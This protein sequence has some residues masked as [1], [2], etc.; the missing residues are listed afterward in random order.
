MPPW[1][2]A[3]LVPGM[4]RDL[5]PWLLSLLVV[6]VSAAWLLLDGRQAFPSSGRVLL[7][8]DDPWGPEGSQHLFD[9]YS[10]SHLIHGILFYAALWLVL[11]RLALRWR[12][13]LAVVVECAWELVENSDAVIERYR[14]ATVSKDYLGDSVLNSVTDVLCMAAGFWLARRLP[15]WASVA[16]VLGFEALTTWLIRDGLALNV[17]MLLWPI[18]AVRDWQAGAMGA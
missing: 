10:P 2:P 8:Y 12:F 18:E 14:T 17:L 16:L 7:W 4:A 13:L 5:R 9:W 11:P 3:C 1:T 15:V 6:A